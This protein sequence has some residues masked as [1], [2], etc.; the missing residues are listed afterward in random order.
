MSEI[1]DDIFQQ[2]P[3]KQQSFRLGVVMDLF[4][5]D[6]AQVQLDG[7]Q[8]PSFKRYA[9]L[10]TYK[11]SID[12]RVVLAII[13]GTYVILGSITTEVIPDN[14][15]GEFET[16]V[17][18]GNTILNHLDIVTADFSGVV[19]FEKTVAMLAN[20]L[21]DGDVKI[22]GKIGFNGAN[23]VSK[24]TVSKATETTASIKT[25]LNALLTAL[26]LVGLI[27]SP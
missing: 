14:P 11:P 5:D 24:Q 10:S 26:H 20:L 4:D 23:P 8:S 16:L 17:V 2:Q 6:T 3:Q 1:K 12:D 9:F 22:S 7:E 19:T 25:Q 27:N 21:V 15:H 13:G 18:T